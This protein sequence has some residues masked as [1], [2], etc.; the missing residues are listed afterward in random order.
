[1]IIQIMPLV[2]IICATTEAVNKD[3]SV[4]VAIQEEFSKLGYILTITVMLK[5]KNLAKQKAEK[6]EK[7]FEYIQKYSNDSLLAEAVIVD[8]KPR[9]TNLFRTLKG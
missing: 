2:Y 4:I 9:Y 1:M 7:R 3:D 5:Q 6:G 8:G